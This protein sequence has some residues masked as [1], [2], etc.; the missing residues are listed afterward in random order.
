MKNKTNSSFNRIDSFNK[1]QLEK[2]RLSYE[3]KLSRKR[4]DLSVW[5]LSAALN[6]S[7]IISVAVAE[8]L[9]PISTGAR[10]WFRN[11]FSR[12]SNK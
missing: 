7:R 8:L 5:E 2:N 4:L 12:R 9:K 11:L 3:V 10:L 1:I 6:P